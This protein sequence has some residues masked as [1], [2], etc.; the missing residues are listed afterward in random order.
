MALM[1]FTLAESGQIDNIISGANMG[2]LNAD[3]NKV[4]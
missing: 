1:G 4:V 2:L 3:R